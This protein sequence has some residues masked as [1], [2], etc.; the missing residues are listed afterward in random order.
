MAP[1]DHR[2]GPGQAGH[3]GRAD[4]VAMPRR[5]EGVS[6]ALL[7]SFQTVPALPPEWT[8]LLERLGAP[9]SGRG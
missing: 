8:L 5:H 2:S 3:R 7:G 4:V 9:P 1:I 6:E